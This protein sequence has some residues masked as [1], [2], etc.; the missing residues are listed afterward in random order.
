MLVM[1]PLSIRVGR[2]LSI[3]VITDK[4]FRKAKAVCIGNSV[5]KLGHETRNS[6]VS[7]SQ[8]NY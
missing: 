4:G 1:F 6:L 5:A 3:Y 7:T 8:P 2:L